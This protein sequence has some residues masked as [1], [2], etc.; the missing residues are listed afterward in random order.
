MST[1]PPGY[2]TPTTV[3]RLATSGG[4]APVNT[5]AWTGLLVSVGGFLVPLGIIG[6]LGVIFSIFGLREAR[7]INAAGFTEDGRS[8]ALAGLIV[9]VVQVVLAI[10]LIVGAVL[11]FTWFNDWITTLTTELQNSN[12]SGR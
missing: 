10:A 6:L 11:A 5:W 1:P 4:R 2:W 9:G 7:K 3:P 12:L 8:L